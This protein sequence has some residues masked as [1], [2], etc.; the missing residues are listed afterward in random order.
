MNQ[1]KTPAKKTSLFH[2]NRK[3]VTNKKIK[4]KNNLFS[5]IVADNSFIA[6][7]NQAVLSSGIILKSDHFPQGLKKFRAMAYKRSS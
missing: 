7:R 3:P 1:I 5:Q 4:R 2:R 6:K